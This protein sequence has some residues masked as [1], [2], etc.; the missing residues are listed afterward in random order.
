MSGWLTRVAFTYNN[1]T[2]EYTIDGDL[3][4]IA[5]MCYE[6]QIAPDT[7]TRH[8]QGYIRFKNP[9]RF[10]T[11]KNWFKKH[12]MEGTH[13]ERC[14]G[15][16][17]QNRDYCTREE[18]RAANCM[19]VEYGTFD[20][21]KGIQG[22]RSDLESICSKISEGATIKDIATNY[23]SQF[24]RYHKGFERMIELTKPEPPVER[25]V[26]VIILYGDSGCGKSHKVMTKY[27]GDPEFL[28]IPKGRDPW[29]KY[30]DQETIFIDEFVYSDWDLR[31]MNEYL[32]KWQLQ[33]DSRYTNKWAYW[34]T[35][36]ISTNEFPGDWYKWENE[37]LREPLLRRISGRCWKVTINN[38]SLTLDELIKTTPDF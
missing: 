31:N 20:K 27:G 30:N 10:T 9:K 13:F 22:N 23:G 34:K 18:T 33:L 3:K 11:V 19:P 4:D 2:P 26:K 21:T 6:H 29:S 8:L 7:G 5:Y 36:I 1:V 38:R 25:E 28:K 15:N 37:K 32:D 16:E 17:E 35:V 12:N 14:E 24:I